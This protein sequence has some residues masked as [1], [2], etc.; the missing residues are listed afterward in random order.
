MKKTNAMRFLDRAKIDYTILEYEHDENEVDG[1]SVANKLKKNPDSVFKTLVLK[2]AHQY[3]V[4][5]VPVQ[6]HLD[7]KRTARTFNEK[8]LDMIAVKDLNAITGYVRG[9]CSPFAMKKEFPLVIDSK[10][11]GHTT[12][13]MSSGAFGLQLEMDPKDFII[14]RNALT[15]DITMTHSDS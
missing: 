7:L 2:G 10:A 8:S 15:D 1:I 13:V 4:A 3:Y 6:E 9:A 11:L 12:I 14:I 5:L